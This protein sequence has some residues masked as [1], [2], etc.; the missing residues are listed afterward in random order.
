[1]DWQWCLRVKAGERLASLRELPDNACEVLELAQATT[2]TLELRIKLHGDRRG[3][4][5]WNPAVSPHELRGW[6]EKAAATVA[7]VAASA[8]PVVA[9]AAKAAAAASEH[10]EFDEFA[11]RVV[12]GKAWIDRTFDRW[13]DETLDLVRQLQTAKWTRH[14]T[15][16]AQ[17]RAM[18]SD[19]NR[20]FAPGINRRMFCT[21]GLVL[22][23]QDHR[24]DLRLS[25][26]ESRVVNLEDM[27]HRGRRTPVRNGDV[28]LSREQVATSA[29]RWCTTIEKSMDDS[30]LELLPFINA[31]RASTIIAF[32]ETRVGVVT[33]RGVWIFSGNARALITVAVHRIPYA[34]PAAVGVAAAA[35]AVCGRS[36]GGQA[37]R[38]QVQPASRSIPKYLEK[39]EEFRVAAMRGQV[40]ALKAALGPR[41]GAWGRNRRIK[42]WWIQSA[43]IAT[44][45]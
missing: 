19:F 27:T 29:A 20:M 7:A 15:N 25:C 8:A 30:S 43:E 42:K 13:L 36:R 38:V 14:A 31:I 32:R 18:T 26:D 3:S 37:A 10:D 9:A 17:E 40:A 33:P 23:I 34:P 22:A 2:P 44:E 12:Q 4:L 45:I 41:W 16:R 1:M 39:R 28:V 11:E 24:Y 21:S 5:R 6:L 35:P